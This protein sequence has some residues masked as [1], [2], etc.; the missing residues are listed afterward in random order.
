VKSS[1]CRLIAV[2]LLCVRLG[3]A[4]AEVLVTTELEPVVVVATRSPEPLSKI[5]GSVTIL[6]DA[7]IQESQAVDVA[8]LLIRTPGISMTREGGVG[9]SASVFIRGAA[10]SQTVVIIDGVQLNDPSVTSG[11]FDFQHFMMGDIARIEI[12]RGAQST[13]YGSQAMGGVIN[14]VTADPTNHLGGNLSAEAGSYGTGKVTAALGG[15]T[16]ALLWRVAGDYY[17][18]SGMTCIDPAFGGRR[19]CATQIAGSSGQIRYEFT[20]DVQLDTR[21]YFMNSRTDFNGYPPPN[22]VLADDGEYGYNQQLLVYTGLTIQSADHSLSNRL[23][24]QYTDSQTRFYDPAALVY[25]QN[26]D[27]GYSGASNETFYGIGR[28]TREEYQGTWALNARTHWVFGLQHELSTINT[29]TPAFDFGGPVPLRADVSLTSGYAQL[30]HELLTGL[31][32]TAGERY[33]HHDLYGGHATGQL[34]AAWALDDNRTIFRASFGQGF[35]A[36]ALYELYAPYYGNLSLKP[37]TSNTWD[38]GVEHHS[39]DNRVMLSATYFKSTSHSLINFFSC[40]ITLV[41][42]KCAVFGGY[43]ANIGETQAYGA[44]VQGAWHLN[45]ATTLAVNY[46]YTHAIDKSAGATT[47]DA[48][49]P[50]RPKSIANLSLSHRWHSRWSSTLAVRYSGPSFDDA[51]NSLRLS[52]YTVVDVRANYAISDRLEA[53]A[54]IENLGGAHYETAYQYGTPGRAGYLGF[55]LTY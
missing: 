19:D 29:D 44:E 47:Y 17:G 1:I 12:L 14:V 36:P 24:V 21:A 32:L 13:L 45:A 20:P 8:D 6:D 11:G 18:S 55:R 37:E 25:A 39:R 10:S 16:D 35:K 23:A 26:P 4:S 28:N 30:Q 54:R 42:P 41:D 33:D 43:Y 48:E 22:Y 5:G 53:Y 34:A 52:G 49:L 15:R 2:S 27:Y 50:R 3:S 31:T 40:P 46:T 7:A 38:A 51:A 9:Q